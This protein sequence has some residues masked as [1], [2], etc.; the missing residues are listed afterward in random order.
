MLSLAY[1][2][3][4]A[5]SSDIKVP[6]LHKNLVE[7]QILRVLACQQNGRR[8]HSTVRSRGGLKSRSSMTR[9]S[10][11]CRRKRRRRSILGGSLGSY[12]WAYKQ[13]SYTSNPY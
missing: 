11:W 6:T 3:F 13:S 9:C 7:G 1:S 8:I 5:S 10:R 12:K 4:I 2:R